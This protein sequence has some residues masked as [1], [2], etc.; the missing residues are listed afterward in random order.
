MELLTLVLGVPGTNWY[1]CT[2]PHFPLSL[3]SSHFF[4]ERPLP[5]YC[6]ELAFWYWLKVGISRWASGNCGFKEQ[7]KA[8]LGSNMLTLLLGD[9]LRVLPVALVIIYATLNLGS[10][11]TGRCVLT[12]PNR[13]VP[14]LRQEIG[15]CLQ[16]TVSLCFLCVSQCAYIDMHLHSQVSCLSAFLLPG[17][18]C[19]VSFLRPHVPWSQPF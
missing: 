10:L 17:V 9:I 13:N 6:Y 2:A 7:S 3:M 18:N 16:S 4:R 11:L 1:S 14:M 5:S 15:N 8:L 19:L 12:F